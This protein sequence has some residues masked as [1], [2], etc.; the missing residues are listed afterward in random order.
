[1]NIFLKNVIGLC[2][3]VL[4]YSV[5]TIANPDDDVFN[6]VVSTVLGGAISIGLVTSKNVKK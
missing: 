6:W 3:F 1:M 4:L 5:M 2:V